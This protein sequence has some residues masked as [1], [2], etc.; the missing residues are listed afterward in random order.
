MASTPRVGVSFQT[1]GGQTIQRPTDQYEKF[2]AVNDT[3]N[4]YVTVAD[5]AASTA[6]DH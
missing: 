1:P 5:D 4:N 3:A 6:G 2:A